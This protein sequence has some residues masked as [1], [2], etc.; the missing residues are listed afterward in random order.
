MRLARATGS[1]VDY[2]MGLPISELGD[3]MLELARQ[4]EEEHEAIE[5]RK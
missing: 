5:K 3:Y 1:G 2:W 4:L